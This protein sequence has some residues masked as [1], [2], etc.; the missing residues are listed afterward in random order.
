MKTKLKKLGYK[1]LITDLEV[2]TKNKQLINKFLEHMKGYVCEMR[3]KKYQHAL[4]HFGHLVEKDFDK[5]TYDEVRKAGGIINESEMSV[6]T[7][8]DIISEVKTAF[9][10][11]FGKNQFFPEVVGG[12]KPPKQKGTLRLPEELPDEKMIYKMIKACSNSRDKFFIALLG[13]DGALRPIEAKGVTFG[14]IHKDKYGYFITIKTAKDSGDKS[15]RTV[16]LIKS[17]PYFEKWSNEYPAEKNDN[18]FV[19]I[20]FSDLKPI[21]QGTIT[22]LFN[23]LKKKLNWK[24]KLSPYCLRHAFITSA[25]KNP[26]WSV[27]ILKKFVG[28]SL[29]S[30]TIAEYQHFGDEDLKDAQLK[31]NGIVK[32]KK[33]KIE[34]RKPIKCPKCNKS[35]EY[36]AEFC[37]FCNMAL[38]Q[39]KMVEI[40]EILQKNNKMMF[41]QVKKMVEGM[42]KVK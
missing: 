32:D 30:N 12:L 37:N 14:S 11:W 31:V 25:S 42:V 34:E 2:T 38:S 29:H 10:Y 7:K 15:T 13:L 1:E 21:S 33:A 28:H 36:D 22:M 18:A 3:L 4:Y 27:P 9:K 35:N 40:D 41:E 16:R 39:K 20:N 5:L 8:K 6:R 23:R 26:D 19:F 17:Q 24:Y